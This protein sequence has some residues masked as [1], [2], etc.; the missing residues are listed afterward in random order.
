MLRSSAT[1]NEAETKVGL[2][3]FLLG[4]VEMGQMQTVFA[5]TIRVAVSSFARARHAAEECRDVHK[6]AGGAGVAS[7]E[8][9]DFYSCSSAER[10]GGTSTVLQAKEKSPGPCRARS[11]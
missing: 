3:G 2:N 7:L 1:R 4:C 10:M 11:F 8:G 6:M 5:Q 9:L